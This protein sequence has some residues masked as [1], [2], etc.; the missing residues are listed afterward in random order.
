MKI[1]FVDTMNHNGTSKSSFDRKFLT[2]LAREGY[3]IDIFSCLSG[4]EKEIVKDGYVYEGQRH[5]SFVTTLA[6]V[7][8]ILFVRYDVVDFR[9]KVNILEFLVLK[10]FHPMCSIVVHK[11]ETQE[12]SLSFLERFILKHSDRLVVPSKDMK[13]MFRKEGIKRCV[14]I[15]EYRSFGKPLEKNIRLFGDSVVRERQYL[16]FS[17][18][19]ESDVD[20]FTKVLRSY[21]KMLKTNRIANNIAFVVL[22]SDTTKEQE[23]LLYTLALTQPLLFVHKSV[24]YEEMRGIVSKSLLFLSSRETLEREREDAI[25]FGV[26]V[27]FLGEGSE[28]KMHT[29]TSQISYKEICETFSYIFNA[30]QKEI[31][32]K[33]EKG[34]RKIRKTFQFSNY[35]HKNTDLYQECIASKRT[36]KL[37]WS[38]AHIDHS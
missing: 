36:G 10:C 7:F 29:F 17:F 2:H 35:V 32:K 13:R 27:L 9:E 15:P 25:G 5:S 37:S 21:E 33:V 26:P 14:V 6:R 16:T 23:L 1:L 38:S 31:E 3:A 28:K 20:M 24:S 22:L 30:S 18:S 19:Q 8:R 12:I 34:R 4:E 11:K